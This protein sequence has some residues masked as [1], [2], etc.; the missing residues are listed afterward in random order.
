LDIL[1]VP[2]YVVF[3]FMR[4]QTFDVDDSESDHMQLLTLFN[5]FILVCIAV[6]VLYFMKVNEVLGLMSALLL[7]VFSAVVP[8]L[9]IFFYFVA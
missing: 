1:I 8:F 7:G 4:I 5:T 2:V 9:I 6:K 3:F